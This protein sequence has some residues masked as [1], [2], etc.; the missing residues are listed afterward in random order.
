MPEHQQRAG[1]E[2]RRVGP[3]QN[4]DEQGKRDTVQNFAAQ[5]VKS[6]AGQKSRSGGQQ[7][8]AEGLIDGFITTTRKLGLVRLAA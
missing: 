4:A 3:Y 7:R 6:K 1:D 2:D 8:P 5:E